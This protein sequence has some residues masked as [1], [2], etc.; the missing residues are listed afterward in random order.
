MA[1]SVPHS[2]SLTMH[3]LAPRHAVYPSPIHTLKVIPPQYPCTYAHLCFCPHS[4]STAR[5]LLAEVLCASETQS[6]ARSTSNPLHLCPQADVNV[7]SAP[8]LI[9]ILTAPSITLHYIT[10]ACLFVS[11]NLTVCFMPHCISHSSA[12]MNV[13]IVT[14]IYPMV[15]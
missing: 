5:G 10:F 6:Y 9:T 12:P 14:K 2:E 3:A 15:P 4:P 7:L 11:P 13:Q 8:S 1:V